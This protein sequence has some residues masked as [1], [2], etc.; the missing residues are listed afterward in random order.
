MSIKYGLVRFNKLHNFHQ[1]IK[2]TNNPIGFSKLAIQFHQKHIDQLLKD[3]VEISEQ[4]YLIYNISKEVSNEEYS[5]HLNNLNKSNNVN[6]YEIYKMTPI[7]S[8]FSDKEVECKILCKKTCK[9]SYDI[10]KESNKIEEEIDYK[11]GLGAA[12]GS[13]AGVSLI[14]AAYNLGYLLFK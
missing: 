6:K 5:I 12:V 13:I 4:E 14:L 1:M 3:K 9:K 11:V 10:K 7:E 8:E 2:I